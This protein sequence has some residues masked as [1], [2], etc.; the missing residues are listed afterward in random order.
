MTE[1][2]KK[3]IRESLTNLLSRREHS[4]SELLHKLQAKGLD[5][6]LCQQVI[7]EFAQ[8]GWQSDQR[9]AASFARQRASRGLGEIR[10]R[11]ELRQRQVNEQEIDAAI[12]ELEVDWFEAART[13]YQKKYPSEASDFKV[14]QKR[15]R[16]LQYKGYT[17]EQIRYA[18]ASPEE[19]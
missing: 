17:P 18:M 8:R 9:F 2:D 1:A 13:L 15:A 3:I 11:G 19:D 6:Q 7:S 10:I 4:Q 16:H 14:R 5:P 12:A